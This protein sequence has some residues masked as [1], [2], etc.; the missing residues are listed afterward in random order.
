MQHPQ[1]NETTIRVKPIHAAPTRRAVLM[2]GAALAGGVLLNQGTAAAQDAQPHG[3]APRAPGDQ[4]FNFK[5]DNPAR[6][7]IPGD[8][9]AQPPGEPGKDYQ[10]VIIP[11]GWALP[12]TVV[13]GEKVFHLVAEE[14][15]H[16]FTKN[17]RAR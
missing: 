10:P 17:L 7:N 2:N 4:D 5:D 9:P 15:S 13:D 3:A 16:E 12:F 11:N 6:H 1:K 14:V 8:G